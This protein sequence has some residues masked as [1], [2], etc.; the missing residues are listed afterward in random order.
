MNINLLRIENLSTDLGQFKLE[1]INLNVKNNEYFV[2]LGPTGAGK[3]ILLETIAGIYSSKKGRIFLNQRDIT[4]IPPKDRNISIVYQDFM[5]FP[6]LNVKQNIEFSLKVKKC[7][8]REIEDKVDKIVELLSI[9]HLLDRYPNTLSGGE[10]QKTSIARAIITE[11]EIL[12]LDEPL[13][14]LDPPTRE[15][16]SG[17]IKIIQKRLGIKVLHVTHNYSEAIQL[18]DRIA[19][20][21]EGRILQVG[22][23]LEVFGKPNSEFVANFVGSKNIFNGISESKNGIYQVKVEDK[24]IE[25]IK[26]KEGEV[27]ICVRPEEIF[28]S[29]NP[30]KT[31]GRNNFK[32]KIT[33]ITHLGSIVNLKIEIDTGLEF[34]AIITEASMKEMDLEIGTKVF[35]AFKATAVH[36]I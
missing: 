20:L 12:L 34:I 10:Q 21:R 15:D 29:K 3:T 5:L 13:G 31:S 32:G 16:L 17:E 23:P 33:D 1:N 18:G 4:H 35:I 9:S 30:I 2:I 28:I 24:K 26:G 14:S 27:K 19:I 25:A 8:K 36:M 11:P 22:E 6:H 7:E